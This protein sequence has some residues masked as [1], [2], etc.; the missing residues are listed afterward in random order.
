MIDGAY[1]SIQPLIA[2]GYVNE[3]VIWAQTSINTLELIRV[4]NATLITTVSK[5]SHLCNIKVSA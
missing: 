4:D 2:C 1:R 3:M 5:V